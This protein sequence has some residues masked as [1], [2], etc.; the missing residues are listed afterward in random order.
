MKRRNPKGKTKRKKE[1]AKAHKEAKKSRKKKVD[2]RDGI[3]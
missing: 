3:F 1:D 2:L